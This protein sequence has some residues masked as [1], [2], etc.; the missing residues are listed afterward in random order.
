MQKKENA[1]GAAKILGSPLKGS[2]D[3]KTDFANFG[4]QPAMGTR[5]A[6][7]SPSWRPTLS[8]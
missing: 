7:D 1:R 3:F 6:G 2:F 8:R 5:T 4:C